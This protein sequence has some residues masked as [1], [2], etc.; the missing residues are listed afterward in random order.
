M[1][2]LT[3]SNN[4]AMQKVII[5]LLILLFSQL[6]IMAQDK[7]L[8]EFKNAIA[9]SPPLPGIV[10]VDYERF[11]TDYRNPNRTTSWSVGLST[12]F[13]YPTKLSFV[14]GIDDLF[15]DSVSFNVKWDYVFNPYVRCY[16]GNPQKKLRS[17]VMLKPSLVFINIE[18]EKTYFF[19]S[20]ELHLLGNWSFS[21][22]FYGIISLGFKHFL[23]Y[24]KISYQS[25][26]TYFPAFRFEPDNL[27]EAPKKWLPATDIAIG[28]RF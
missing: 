25:E 8:S 6:T 17:G 28:Y 16:F 2:C 21:R 22:R 26:E 15:T 5:S 13:G 23:K 11:L 7:G 18:N 9:V 14:K 24:D 27:D 19:P 20:Y 12:G 10:V 1:S 4:K 3:I